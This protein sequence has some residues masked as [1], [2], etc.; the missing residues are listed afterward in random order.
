L[1]IKDAIIAETTA[2][3]GPQPIDRICSEL[4]MA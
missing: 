2:P 1:K 3:T 4:I